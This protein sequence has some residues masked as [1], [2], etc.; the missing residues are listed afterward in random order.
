MHESQCLSVL[1]I[2]L[3]L[4]PRQLVHKA[5]SRL[6]QHANSEDLGWGP[7]TCR[8]ASTPVIWIRIRGPS[9]KI[10]LKLSHLAAWGQALRLE[11]GLEGTL[12]TPAHQHV[13]SLHSA[14]GTKRTL[15]TSRAWEPQGTKSRAVSV[16]LNTAGLECSRPAPSSFQ[17]QETAGWAAVTCR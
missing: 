15:P 17:S 11:G 6:P 5:E 1:A 4:S 7:G 16:S 3:A 13:S 12:M 2:I 8:L 10:P 14:V 9:L